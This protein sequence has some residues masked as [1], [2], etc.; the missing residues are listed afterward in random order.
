[1]YLSLRL[2]ICIFTHSLHPKKQL[3][4]NIHVLDI[5]GNKIGDSGAV[6]LSGMM[7]KLTNLSVTDCGLGSIG[8]KAICTRAQSTSLES[9]DLS[10]NV[11]GYDGWTELGHLLLCNKTLKTLRLVSCRL[12]GIDIQIISLGLTFSGLE[13]F[14]ISD[15]RLV[16]DAAIVLSAAL[17]WSRHVDTLKTLFMRHAGIG[18]TAMKEMIHVL[19]RCTKLSS[20]DLSSNRLGDEGLQ[21]FFMID[22]IQKKGVQMI[23]KAIV[24]GRCSELMILCLSDNQ[25]GDEGAI[26]IAGALE[27][28]PKLEALDLNRNR[29]AKNGTFFLSLFH[30][31]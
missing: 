4:D 9:L 7:S 13:Y 6:I 21:F 8:I 23:C 3:I 11:A 14:D 31:S 30:S 19:E 25:I 26:A 12:S 22:S 2:T 28:L 17:G 27:H 15:N 1:M 24:D 5:S 18:L 10:R 29:I 20:I 16:F